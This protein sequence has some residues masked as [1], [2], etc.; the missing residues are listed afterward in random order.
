MLI[1]SQSFVRWIMR[2]VNSHYI[3][4]ILTT[5]ASQITSLTVVYSTV[6]SDP[7]QRKHQGSASLALVRGIHRDQWIPGTK[8]QIRGKWWRHHGDVR[9]LKSSHLVRYRFHSRLKSLHPVWH[10]H[11][12]YQLTEVATKCYGISYL[13]PSFAPLT[14]GNR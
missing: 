9:T 5:M 10:I 13:F 14:F 12:G 3:D 4:V 2:T 1:T 8:G 7:D 11:L 6:Y